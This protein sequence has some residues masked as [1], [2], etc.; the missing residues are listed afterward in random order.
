MDFPVSPISSTYLPS[1]P[2]WSTSS[3]LNR[4]QINFSSSP[5]VASQMEALNGVYARAY[6]MLSLADQ[7][8][9][10]EGRAN[11][12][13]SPTRSTDV[14]VVDIAYFDKTH[15]LAWTP[16]SRFI[17]QV[18]QIARNQVNQGLPLYPN[19]GSVINIG[20]N[21]YTLSVGG[22]T[23]TLSATITPGDTN[24]TALGKIAQAIDA[25]NAGVTTAI[26]QGSG[27]IK[28]NLYGENGEANAFSLADLVGN[29]VS[30]SGI[31]DSTQTAQDA[32]YL[33]NGTVYIQPD[34]SV[35]VM[36]GHLQVNLKGSGSA[37]VITGPQTVVA[38]V[39]SLMETMNNF[40]AYTAGNRYLNPAL[41]P[42]WSGLVHREAGILSKYGLEAGSQGQVGLDTVKFTEELGKD[43][44]QAAAA[45]GGLASRVRDFVKKLHSY[46]AAT[47]LA[48]PPYSR[49]GAVYLRSGVSTPWYHPRAGSFWGI[50]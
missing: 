16:E 18:R 30:A 36:G 26:V 44:S 33:L 29:V 1:T 45:M 21:T 31:N 11:F 50:A 14:K 43:A 9:G 22:V 28:L 49:Y 39:Q 7:L 12:S 34:N 3:S 5:D 41:S 2:S 42:A 4:L 27:T 6:Q 38:L 10:D 15:Y 46:P 40:S 48:S 8:S 20:S 19:D 13:Q 24:A 23:Y 32:K 17:F 47:L 35:S 37:T 25:V